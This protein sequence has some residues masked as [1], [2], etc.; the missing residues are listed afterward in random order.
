MIKIH[1]NVNHIYMMAGK[2]KT[3]VDHGTCKRVYVYVTML[4][5]SDKKEQRQS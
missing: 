1:K 3:R 5:L 2:I 4:D